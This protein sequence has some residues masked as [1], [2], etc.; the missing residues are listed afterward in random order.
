VSK[1]APKKDEAVG[2]V[3]TWHCDGIT[4]NGVGETGV[5]EAGLHLEF[6]ADGKYQF[7]RGTAI[8]REGTYTADSEKVPAEM[9]FKTGWGEKACPGIFRVDKEK[10]TVCFADG[11]G[12]RPTGF[13]SEVGA[14]D[15]LMTFT[16]VERK[17]K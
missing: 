11:G 7:R 6:T 8:L 12:P 10:L 1:E 14:R 17:K 3:G 4:A 13:A 5:A 2:L 9:E 15:A 16:L